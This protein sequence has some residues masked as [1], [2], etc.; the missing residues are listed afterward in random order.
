MT[1]S[2]SP[3]PSP[4]WLDGITDDSE[5]E[6]ARHRLLLGLACLFHSPDGRTADLAFVLDM[7]PNAFSLMKARGRVSPEIAIDIERILGREHFPR[8]LFHPALYAE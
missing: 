4:K 1:A 7:T 6:A 8:E 2:T 3:W 5:R